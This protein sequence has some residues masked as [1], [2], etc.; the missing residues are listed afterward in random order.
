MNVLVN[1]KVVFYSP[2]YILLNFP[3]ISLN[4]KQAKSFRN[5]QETAIDGQQL[6]LGADV[7]LCPRPNK[8]IACLKYGDRLVGVVR[9]YV[10][11]GSD[12]KDTLIVKPWKYLGG[13]NWDDYCKKL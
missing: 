6:S 10:G 11:V 4:P 9:F 2:E 5:G 13:D 12:S 8:G 7:P 1:G 3:V